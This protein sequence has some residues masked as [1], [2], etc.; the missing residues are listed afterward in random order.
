MCAGN[1]NPPVSIGLPVH[2]GENYLRE[3]ID[4]L[5]AQSY[6]DFELIISDNASTDSTATICQEYAR[7]DS[8]IRYCR[9]EQNIGAA[10]NYNFVFERS[11]GKYFKWAAHDDICA[12]DFLRR[13]VEALDKDDSLVLCYTQVVL[14]DEH[15][16]PIGEYNE[17]KNLVSGSAVDRFEQLFQSPKECNAVF[18]VIRSDALARTSLIGSY[19]AADRT[20]LAELALLGRFHEVPERLFL[21]RDHP[22]TSLRANRTNVERVTWFNPMKAN[23]AVLPTW[24]GLYGYVNAII[25][26]PNSIGVKFACCRLVMKSAWDRRRKLVKELIAAGMLYCGRT[27][28]REHT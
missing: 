8:R 28:R 15:G 16:C 3:A 25:R 10:G 24:K 1:S 23:K 19:F 9:F 20:L 18:G 11:R 12:P 27:T 22:H 21:R 2:D 5:L 6:T 4:S 14:I 13:C 26:S 7:R 17:G